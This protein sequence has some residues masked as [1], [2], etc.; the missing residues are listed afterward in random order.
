MSGLTITTLAQQVQDLLDKTKQQ[1]S[2][3]AAW[4][5]GSAD[6]GPNNDGRYPFVD[7]TGREILVPSPASFSDMTSGPAAQA[8]VAKVAAELARD[9]AKG[10]AD[11]SD[12]QRIL[13]EAARGAAVDA[14]NLAQQHRDHAGTSEANARYWAE[15]AQG[16]GQGSSDDR[17]IVEQ[18]AAETAD[19]AALAAQDAQDAAASAALAATFDPNLFDKKSDTLAASRLTGMIDP[20]RIPVLVGQ[21]PVV[22]SGGIA[23]LTGGQQTGIMP[24]TL[25]ATTDGRRWV[26]SG[27]GSMTAEASYIEQ[28][29]VTPVWSVIADKPSFFPSNIANVAG[30]QSALDGKSAVGHAHGWSEITGKPSTFASSAHGH[31]WDEITGKPSTYPA[32]AHTHG[33]SGVD[34]LQTALNAKASL[35]GADFTGNV[36]LPSSTTFKKENANSGEGGQFA[37]EKSDQYG[38]AFNTIVDVN[39]SS[40]RFFEGGGSFRGAYLPL[41][42]MP[43]GVNARI[44]TSNDFNPANYSATTHTH[45]ISGVTGLQAALDGKLNNT[46]PTYAGTITGPAITTTTAATAWRQKDSTGAGGVAVL[47]YKDSDLFYYLL[48]NRD[49]ANGSWNSL[50]PFVMNLNNGVVTMNHGVDVN[51]YLNLN[52]K[53]VYTDA[54]PA[55]RITT[56]DPNLGTGGI[57]IGGNNRLWVAHSGGAHGVWDTSNFNA[58]D[59]VNWSDTSW[60]GGAYTL[61][62]RNG[63]GGTNFSGK[64]VHRS[65]YATADVW[66]GGIEIQE[67]AGVANTQF[68]HAYAPTLTFHWGAVAARALYMSSDAWLNFGLQGDKSQLGKFRVQQIDCND[69]NEL[70]LSKSG[71]TKLKVRDGGATTVGEHHIE[72]SL[73]MFGTSPTIYF[74]DT[75][76]RSA[77]IHVNSNTFHIL[78]GAG[79]GSEAWETTNG[80][81]PLTINLD[82][83]EAAFGGVVRME[84]GNVFCGYSVYSGDGHWFRVRGNSGI[85]WENWGGGFYMQDTDWVRVYNGKN[86][87]CPAQVR[88]NTVVGES[89]RRLK[90]N[91]E[92]ITD[93]TQKVEALTG[94]TFDWKRDGSAGMGFIAQDFEQVIPALV[95]EDADG[96]KGVEYGPVVALL[97][98]ALKQTNARVAVLEGRV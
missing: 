14:R 11:R 37:L 9:L 63:D 90:T 47:H 97:V 59:K 49:D 3:L 83:N 39:G 38:F 21:T 18:L 29:D 74:R 23:N 57:W 87:Y 79:N 64:T 86:L 75:D 84:G 72:G 92:T 53:S 76:N 67:V 32:T 81:W 52:G 2:N 82:S 73:Q 89:D 7:L 20:A 61:V 6:G 33:I 25:I 34:G 1:N 13:S 71:A 51:G 85:Y 43:S 16:A 56:A 78:R 94:V 5:G 8:T 88:A 98:E 48:T 27:E 65:T 42:Q 95:T 4:L 24:G 31:G 70:W 19:N 66:N 91:I 12:A 50:R 30:L 22:S 17:E 96:M 28:G 41:D 68:G 35:S 36:T 45:A 55:R 77:M 62:R 60:D 69:G 26:Y 15:L 40:L 80:R 93:A 10:H 46:N 44:W 54:N 58:A